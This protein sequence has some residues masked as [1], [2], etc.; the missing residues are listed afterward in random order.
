MENRSAFGGQTQPEW[1]IAIGEKSVGPMSASEVYERVMSG[2]L[3]WISY[4][5][6][7]GMNGWERLCDVPTFQAAVPP[8]PAV[9]PQVQPPAPPSPKM[10]AKEWFL[11]FEEAQHGPFALDEVT[12]MAGVGKINSEVLGWKDGMS[13]WEKVGTLSTFSG[14][15]AGTPPPV[16]TSTSEAAEKAG[17]EKRAY[18]RR[19]ILAKIMIAEKDQLIVGMARDISIGGMQVLSEFVPS[20][21]GSR[22]KLN[23]SAPEPTHPA[24]PPF[25]AEGVV[26][27]LHQD[28]RGFSF[29]FDELTANARQII[30]E[31]IQG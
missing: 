7:E 14:L 26:V 27:R 2:E 3:T 20:S 25:V 18:S 19:P 29:R 22:L 24:F 12:G 31:I 21:V 10:Q 6:K 11:F 23:V 17:R 5:W 30:E 28:R 13:G 9:K 4:V 16:T 15:F 8:P 1:F